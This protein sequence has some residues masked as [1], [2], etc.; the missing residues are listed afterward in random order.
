MAETNQQTYNTVVGYFSSEQSA[1]AAVRALQAAGFT[2]D[3]IGIAGRAEDEGYSVS[4]R[5]NTESTAYTEGHKTG[6][7]ASGFWQRIRNFFEG[8]TAE[9]YADENTRGDL[10]TR[11]VTDSYGYDPDDFRQSLGPSVPEERSRYFSERFGREQGSVLVTVEAGDRR[12]EAEAILE[13]NGGDLGRDTSTWSS[14]TQQQEGTTETPGTQKIRLYGEVLRVHRDRL[15]R[16]EV[17]LRKETI[18]EDQNVKVPVTREE[19]VLE[20]VPVAGEQTAPGAQIGKETEIRVPLSE[21][22]VSIEKEPVVR[23]EVKVGKREVTNVESYDEKVR[24]EELRVEDETK[25][26]AS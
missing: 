9:P 10:A 16:G 25:K 22:R 3:Q 1:E 11:E 14:Q 12:A 19:L 15:Q 26:K 13:S 8:D 6:K 23:E 2:R 18:T 4:D 5:R 7:A 21:E 20:R 17:R 24:R